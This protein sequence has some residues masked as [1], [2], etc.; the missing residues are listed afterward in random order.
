MGIRSVDSLF[1]QLFLNLDQT[2]PLQHLCSRIAHEFDCSV[3]LIG[4]SGEVLAAL[5]ALPLSPLRDQAKR[6]EDSAVAD[7]GAVGLWQFHSRTVELPTQRCRLTLATHRHQHNALSDDQI[8]T[9]AAA[10][11]AAGAFERA[12]SHRGLTVMSQIMRDLARGIDRSLEHHY[13]PRM[14]PFGFLAHHPV[15]VTI[16]DPHEREPLPTARL[17]EL[18]DAG[19]HVGL[20]GLLVTQQLIRA[21]TVSAVHILAPATETARCWLRT[22]FPSALIAHS[23]EFQLLED[24]PRALHEAEST[25]GLAQRIRD[26]SPH[27]RMPTALAYSSLPLSA[28]AVTTLPQREL[29]ERCGSVLAPLDDSPQLRATLLTYLRCGMHIPRTARAL[30][31]HANSVRYR[32]DRI[33]ELCGVDLQSAIDLANLTMM[34]LPELLGDTTHAAT[35]RP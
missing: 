24:V 1:T 34:L 33:E 23:S 13:W 18:I 26:H 3:A 27:D 5:G 32:L 6:I 29:F 14:E 20:E 8:S 10:I 21:T 25:L 15:Q 12:E 30:F 16:V 31:L 22:E 28:W 7:I 19:T 2:A 35:S 11:T 9:A 17:L 4:E